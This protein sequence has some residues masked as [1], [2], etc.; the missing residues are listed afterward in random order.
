MSSV[1]YLLRRAL[2]S[3]L[4]IVGIATFLFFAF[5]L[6][7]GD[8]VTFL[9][10][11]G[12]SPETAARLRAKWGLDQPLHVQYFRY[13]VNMATGDAGTSKVTHQPVLEYVLPRLS[14]SL[15]LVLPSILTAF[16]LGSLYG[17]VLGNREGSL[18]ERYGIFPPTLV[19]TTPDFFIGILVLFVFSAW[20]GLFP[21]SGMVTPETRSVVDSHWGFYLTTDFWYHYTLP[22]VAITLK[23]LY[24]PALVM[25]GS[26]VEVAGQEFSF[27][28]EMVGLGD[29]TRF[30]HIMHHA[31]LPVVTL[32][33][34]VTATAISG[35]VLIEVVFNWPGIGKLVYDSILTRDLAVIQFVFLLIAIW[36]VVGN[37]VVDIVYTLL[38]PR[39]SYGDGQSG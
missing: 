8:Y 37:F 3:V 31:S 16:V 17:A 34:A 12:A 21:P 2:V 1:Q 13:M 33:P 32:L 35:L 5:R 36:I 25:R 39:I 20:L 22:F 29:L 7:P 6:M 26:V 14:N 24:Y 11:E 10:G 18:L 28:H 38:D 15:I 9:V 19:G 30:K 4:L 23:Y 27:Y